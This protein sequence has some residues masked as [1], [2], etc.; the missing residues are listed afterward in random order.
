MEEIGEGV[1]QKSLVESG[2]MRKTTTSRILYGVYT[3][4]QYVVRCRCVSDNV[5]GTDEHLDHTDHLGPATAP[6]RRSRPGRDV[7]GCSPCRP[8]L[9]GTF[10]RQH[11]V[12]QRLRI[13]PT[14]TIRHGRLSLHQG[15]AL[16]T[17][18]RLECCSVSSSSSSSSNSISSSSSSCCCCCMRKRRRKR[19]RT[20]EDGMVEGISSNE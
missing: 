8:S 15:Q 11:F 3:V 17:F 16:A 1:K 12:E 20:R 13:T 10:C 2:R 18:S 7:A 19:T 14:S 5:H 6:R 9:V 4:G